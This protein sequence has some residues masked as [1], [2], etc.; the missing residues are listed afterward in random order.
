[1]HVMFLLFYITYRCRTTVGYHFDKITFAVRSSARE[2]AE[3]GEDLPS[4]VKF[5]SY[6]YSESYTCGKSFEIVLQNEIIQRRYS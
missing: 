5:G 1:M 3:R 6:S 4:R 2:Y